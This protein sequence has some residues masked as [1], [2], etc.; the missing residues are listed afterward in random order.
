MDPKLQPAVASD[1]PEPEA[2]AAARLPEAVRPARAQA[3]ARQRLAAGP[4]DDG[5]RVRRRPCS[6]ALPG[7]LCV[8]GV[9]LV[10]VFFAIDVTYPR[11]AEVIFGPRQFFGL[12]TLWVAGYM[13][14][15][16]DLCHP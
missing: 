10:C 6:P 11:P 7:Q 8:F 14:L 16:S 1:P 15:L 12:R 3:T 5:R 4:A 9:L 13:M 2:A